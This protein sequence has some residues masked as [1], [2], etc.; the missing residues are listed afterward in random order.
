M[1]VKNV[2]WKLLRK[3]IRLL[4]KKLLLFYRLVIVVG[5]L[6]GEMK[7]FVN[8]VM[9]IMISVLIVMSLMRVN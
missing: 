1:K 5:L 8:S 4:G 9:V 3:F 7:W 6:L 2:I